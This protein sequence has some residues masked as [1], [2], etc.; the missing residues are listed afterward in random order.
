MKINKDQILFSLVIS[1]DTVKIYFSFVQ[2][3]KIY[4]CT[5]LTDNHALIYLE[6]GCFDLS[7]APNE[8]VIIIGSLGHGS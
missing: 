5:Q 6:C 3:L 1:S 7:E 4:K 8:N 2:K